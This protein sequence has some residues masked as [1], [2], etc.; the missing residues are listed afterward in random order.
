MKQAKQGSGP[1]SNLATRSAPGSSS[2]KVRIADVSRQNARIT[3]QRF[4]REPDPPRASTLR[5][6]RVLAREKPAREIPQPAQREWN[7]RHQPATP[8]D[9]TALKQSALGWQPGSLSI[10]RGG[11]ASQLL[12]TDLKITLKVTYPRG[13]MGPW[14]SPELHCQSCS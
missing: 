2:R 13:L 14:R 11:G 8:G 1:S 12:T 5:H 4:D 3:V 6:R 9:Q 10:E 7:H